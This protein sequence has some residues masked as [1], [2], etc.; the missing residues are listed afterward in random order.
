MRKTG[1]ILG[2]LLG[3]LAVAALLGATTN[4]GYFRSLVVA[5]GLFKVEDDGTV[6]ATLGSASTVD[7]AALSANVAHLNVAETITG[8]WVNT[9]NPWADNEVSDSITVGS[10]GNLAAPPAI[11]GTTPNTGRFTTLNTTGAVT[12][13]GASTITHTTSGELDIVQGVDTNFDLVS[14]GNLRFWTDANA[15]GDNDFTWYDGGANMVAFLD[16]STPSFRSY[17]SLYTGT[18]SLAGNPVLGI[19]AA[20]GQTLV[21]DMYEGNELRWRWTKHATSDDLILG[22]APSGTVVEN[23]VYFSMGSGVATFSDP[24]VAPAFTASA[25][26]PY[27]ETYETDAASNAKRVR[28]HNE[29]GVFHMAF[30]D[31]AAENSNSFITAKRSGYTV[32]GIAAHG[33]L[34]TS[35]TNDIEAGGDIVFGGHLRDGSSGVPTVKEKQTNVVASTITGSRD[36]RGKLSISASGG[37][38][39][40]GK[41][42]RVVFNAAMG[43]AP[44][45]VLGSNQGSSSDLS[46]QWSTAAESTTGFDVYCQDGLVDDE[47]NDELVVTWIA[48]E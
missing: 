30:W 44:Y 45:V 5:G 18:A 35:S 34:S 41:I 47:G 17:H 32:T 36:T 8:N 40:P 3:V 46:F 4:P 43:S 10:G 38:I 29:S 25:T 2:G 7:D 27:L 24:P 28:F 39:A 33:P 16:T 23:P 48:I 12:L 19:Q 21:F 9:A 1:L 31:D 15:N 37:N 22:R 6:T 11:G 26:A 42:C 13:E 14:N 20:S